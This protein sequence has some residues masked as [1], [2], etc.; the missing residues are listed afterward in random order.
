M[1]DPN[2]ETKTEAPIPVVGT[3]ADPIATLVC[4][5]VFVLAA[6]HVPEALE[7]TTAQVTGIG[8][9]VVL[10]ASAGRAIW[11]WFKN[12][13]VSL[14][15]PIVAALGGLVLLASAFGLPNASE[16]DPNTIA[17]LASGITGVL[18]H[19][20]GARAKAAAKTSS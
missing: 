10:L 16:I 7:L 11:H 17:M 1:A 13:V 19:L 15:D 3:K 12:E 4:G 20:R 8:S 9:T 5:I 18:T 2:A 14:Q 6:L